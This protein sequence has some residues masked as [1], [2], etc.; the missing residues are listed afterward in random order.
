VAFSEKRQSSPKQ[1]HVMSETIKPIFEDFLA[2]INDNR[3]NN[4]L[5]KTS[6]VITQKDFGKIMGML[7]QDAK[8]EFERD[9]YE[10]SKSDWKEISKYVV[11]EA[12]VVLRED[13][14]NILDNY[15]DN[16]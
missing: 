14:L 13:W 2:Y 10:I 8:D 4:I 5:S 16:S 3:L 11:K 6:D 12:S 1:P 9:E 15:S 7:V